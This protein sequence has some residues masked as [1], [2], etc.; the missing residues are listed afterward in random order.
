M[1][2][3]R[4]ENQLIHHKFLGRLKKILYFSTKII[5]LKKQKV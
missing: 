1:Q 4:I 5:K 3:L 2:S